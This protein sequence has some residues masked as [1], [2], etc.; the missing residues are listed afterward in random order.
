MKPKNIEEVKIWKN[1]EKKIYEYFR[2][3]IEEAQFH[4]ATETSSFYNTKELQN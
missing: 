2:E 3:K 4:W 1:V